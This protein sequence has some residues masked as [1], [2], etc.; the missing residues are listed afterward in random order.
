MPARGGDA[1]ALLAKGLALPQDEI[2]MRIAAGLA[3]QFN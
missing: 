3:N 1:C 2:V